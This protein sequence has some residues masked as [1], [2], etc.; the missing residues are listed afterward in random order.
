M[1]VACIT[2]P[3]FQAA[4]KQLEKA[5]TLCDAVEIRTDMIE[6]DISMLDV[7][8]PLIDCNEIPTYH[9][10]DETP[11]DLDAIVSS[12]KQSPIVKIAT[13]ANCVTDSLRMLDI[14]NRYSHVA[15]M[16][17][18]HHGEITRIL[19]PIYGSPLTFSSVGL[20]SAPGQIEAETLVRQYR[21]RSLNPKTK[22]YGLIGNPV[23]QSPSHV[24]HNS[25]FYKNK[26]DAVYIKMCLEE[27]E[28]PLFFDLVKKLDFKGLSV[29]LPFKEKLFDYIDYI[30]CKADLIGAV[31][32]LKI[33][34]GILGFNTDGDGALDV[35][36]K[37]VL[38][39]GLKVVIL[40]AGG[41]SKAIAYEAKKRGAHVFVCSRRYG[42][43]TKIPPYD[44]LIT[45]LPVEIDHEPIA[46][47]IVFDINFKRKTSYLMKKA[48]LKGCQL[49]FGEEMFDAQAGF[50]FSKWGQK[51]S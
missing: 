39:K 7:S 48:A 11:K 50:Q 45:T 1:L 27:K 29:T 31:N 40:G 36:E 22:I 28:L 2:G 25:Y 41:S 49:I 23:V 35:L 12:L 14:V 43:L 10:F 13:K 32:T 38:V 51:P 15:G 46:G 37:R 20:P 3:D 34:N 24:T 17:M 21:F 8:L 42:N 33:E 44:V 19:A 18:G 9:N 47:S 5:K 6:E 16:C 26:K 4:K 30:D